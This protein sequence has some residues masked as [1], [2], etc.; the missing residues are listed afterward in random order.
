MVVS[1]SSAPSSTSSVPTVAG[2]VPIPEGLQSRGQKR[3]RDP[4]AEAEALMQEELDRTR[5]EELSYL[6]EISVEFVAPGPPWRD[7]VTQE[8]LDP[9]AVQAGME[10]ERDLMRQFDVMEPI[11]K[12]QAERLG[13]QVIRSRWV[14]RQ[15]KDAVRARWVVQQI[16]DGSW[17]DGYAATPSHAGQ[18]VLLF[19]ALQNNWALTLADV[20]VAFLHADLPKGMV[21]AIIPP[22]TE[23]VPPGTPGERLLLKKAQYGLRVAPKVFQEHFAS[24]V[25]SLGWRRSR[26]DP[27]LYV[28]QSGAL[29]SVHAD[30]IL[31]ACEPSATDQLMGAL[32]SMFAIR[33]EGEI[34]FQDWMR[35]LGKEWKK[36]QTLDGVVLAVR[37]PQA[38][39]QSMLDIFDLTGKGRSVTTPFASNRLLVPEGSVALSMEEAQK[40]KRAVGKGLWIILERPEIGYITKEL[41]RGVSSPKEP[42]TVACK[43]WLRYLRSTQDLVLALQVDANAS[44]VEL[45]VVSDAAFGNSTD[46]KSTSGG[47]VWYRGFLL[48]S[49]SKTQSVIAQ[50]T[51]ESELLAANYACLEGKH[52]QAILTD[53]GITT[54]LN[55]Y[56]DSTS[57]L[58][59]ASRVGP[60][61]LRHIAIRELWLQEEVQARRVLCHYLSGGENI[62]DVMTKALPAPVFRRWR[63]QLGVRPLSSLV[64]GEQLIGSVETLEL[65]CS[66]GAASLYSQ[67]DWFP[68]YGSWRWSAVCMVLILAVYGAWSLVLQ[69]CRC[70]YRIVPWPKRVST[71][72]MSVQSQTTCTAVRGTLSTP[73]PYPR[74]LPLSDVYAGAFED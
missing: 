70:I 50:S 25:A 68:D 17:V 13:A 19:Q 41:A 27:Q 66:D 4:E 33:R 60:G 14:L 36:V 29:M 52:I 61:K 35:Y 11:T 28:H 9:V 56:V 51:C 23:E 67:V 72:T 16:N 48:C 62:S 22:S 49:W 30:D 3:E 37:V 12:E 58:G 71:R 10:R 59:V 46:W 69:L 47:T 20:S 65:T 24:R 31:L 32:E 2:A 73:T 34:G 45:Q 15:K 42:H 40:F 43:R 44:P 55:L 39:W 7:E 21:V 64:E 63:L 54:E 26:A 5:D 57:A 74:F 38:Y 18:R 1:A 53:I 8:I 6:R